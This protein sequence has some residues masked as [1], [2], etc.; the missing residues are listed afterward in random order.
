M[1]KTIAFAAVALL[2]VAGCSTPSE[3]RASVKPTATPA[4]TQSA[5]RVIEPGEWRMPDC[6]DFNPIDE[7]ERL[8]CLTSDLGEWR[9]VYTYEPYHA[10][11]VP[12]CDGEDGPSFLPCALKN[13]GRDG[14]MTVLTPVEMPS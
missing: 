9:V 2:A 8:P 13:T 14:L 1:R 7:P 4:P 5:K 10:L 3:K 12:A 11:V 6:E